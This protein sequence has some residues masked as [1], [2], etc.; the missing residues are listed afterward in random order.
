MIEHR[1]FATIGSVLLLLIN[2]PVWADESSEQQEY[3]AC[4]TL[5]PS[6]DKSADAQACLKGLTWKPGN[7]SVCCDKPAG[8]GL[9]ASRLVRFPSPVPSGDATNDLV[10]MEWYEPRD[11][12]ARVIRAP[13]VLVVHESGSGMQVGRL[14]ARSLCLKGLHA[15]LIHLPYYGER[16]P[17]EF[18][19]DS[20]QFLRTMR[21]GIAD[22]R[23]ARDAISVLPNV[24]VPHISVQGTSL[25]GFVVATSAALDHG[26]AGTF[27]MLAG[28][29]LYDVIMTGKKDT[30]KVREL[31]TEAGYTDQK[32]KDLL[33][34]IEPTRLAHRLDPQ[35][36]W[37]Y[38][39]LDDSV[40]PIK[41]A[42]VLAKA[43]HLEAA[44]HI[45]VGGNHY[46][47]IAQF[48]I[49]L[50][51]MVEQIRALAEVAPSSG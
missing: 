23:R 28:G 34:Q 4:D 39:A 13:A 33:W 29:D 26:F 32:L 40:V 36:T 2:A 35:T 22:V 41:N 50:N 48:P 44:H 14:F 42:L 30:A 10:A 27:I 38:S 12:E 18:H 8:A 49:I 24:N 1:I 21:Q 51:H 6:K 47:A 19:R 20:S 17:K 11:G 46:T 25:G 43:A 7:F 5:A 16:R 3:Q 45:R 9:L 31:F 37:L 15:F